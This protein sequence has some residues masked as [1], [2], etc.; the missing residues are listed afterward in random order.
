[1]KPA[2]SA[3]RTTSDIDQL[4]PV[5]T[6]LRAPGCPHQVPA[7][8]RP[9]EPK[10]RQRSNLARPVPLSPPTKRGL[11]VNIEI[12]RLEED[13]VVLWTGS[14]FGRSSSSLPSLASPRTATTVR[15]YFA[16]RVVSE[17]TFK[18][19]RCRPQVI[20][21]HDRPTAAGAGLR[22]RRLEG[23]VDVDVCLVVRRPRHSSSQILGRLV[24]VRVSRG[25]R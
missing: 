18:Y 21:R 20:A 10:T 8:Q 22:A 17:R 7:T 11:H 25:L 15:H 1:M 5:S 3:R 14:A 24:Q 16:S 19:L 9:L 4:L 23:P 12:E 6:G 13:S 2:T